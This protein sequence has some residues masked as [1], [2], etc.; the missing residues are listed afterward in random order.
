MKELDESDHFV[1]KLLRG[2]GL[3]TPSE[4]FTEKVK[5]QILV[6][7]AQKPQITY[8]PLIAKKGWVGIAI[9]ILTIYGITLTQ[10]KSFIWL[11]SI[12]GNLSSLSELGSSSFNQVG[13]SGFFIDLV[14]YFL[15][16]SLVVILLLK[17]NLNRRLRFNEIT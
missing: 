16:V 11:K 4:N 3:E 12:W 5:E 8:K 13:L 15:F 7:Q 9:C 14:L 17:Y 1:R 10:A 2:S 6:Y